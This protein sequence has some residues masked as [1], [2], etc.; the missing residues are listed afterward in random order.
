MAIRH[1]RDLCLVHP[2]HTITDCSICGARTKR[3]LPLGQRTYVC[4]TC[5][6]TSPRDKNS[7]A[8]IAAR[9]GFVPAD[10]EDVGLLDHHTEA[11]KQSESGVPRL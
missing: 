9:A 3:R 8:V 7:A 4:E 2:A 5:G 10:V 1:E 6:A 11:R